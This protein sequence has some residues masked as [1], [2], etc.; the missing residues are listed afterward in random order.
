MKRRLITMKMK[1]IHFSDKPETISSRLFTHVSNCKVPFNKPQSGGLWAS[2]Y[3]SNNKTN[4]YH[5]Y[6][7]DW[8]RFCAIELSCPEHCKYYCIFELDSDRIAIINSFKDYLKLIYE[9]PHTLNDYVGLDF[10]KISQSYD[11]IYL[12]K[13]GQLECHKLD[14][15]IL[16]INGL[17]YEDPYA[18]FG[19]DCESLL[20]FNLDHIKVDS[21]C[22]GHTSP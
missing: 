8:E 17:K 7:S 18:L 1:L 3:T 13:S 16:N 14:T 2:P 5:P 15:T 11:A 12:T 21:Y 19:W 9:Y 4:P 22:I 20:I 6:L 10:E